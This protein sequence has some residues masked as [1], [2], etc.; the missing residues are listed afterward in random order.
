VTGTP[1]E[2]ARAGT[3]VTHQTGQVQT[4]SLSPDGNELVYLS[5]NGGHGNLWIT[6]TDGTAIRQLTFERDPSTAVGVPV[7]S[8][9][10]GEIV[11]I[12]T[13]GGETGEWL[14]N[15]DGSGMRQFIRDGTSALWSQDGRWVY[16]EITRSGDFCIE[17]MPLA[18][19][20]AVRVRCEN[21]GITLGIPDASTLYFAS[22]TLGT[23]GG[24]DYGIFRARPESGPAEKLG[25]VSASQAPF[26]SAVF[27]LLLSPDGKLLAGPLLEGS[28]CD[29]WAMP[30]AGGP[31]RRLIDFGGR[32]VLVVRRFAWSPDGRFIYAAVAETDADV[33][34]LSGVLPGR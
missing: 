18:G 2:N 22:Q 6:R 10:G 26:D 31:M 24:W 33:V 29:F 3:R 4:P 25:S 11:F 27:Q 7:W 15:S 19:G 20:P 8:T 12:M 17:K 5:D 34:L 13:K 21:A 28:S 23:S 9:A 16:H 30:A 1:E 14:V 32:P